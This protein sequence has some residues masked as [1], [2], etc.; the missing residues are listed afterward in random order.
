MVIMSNISSQRCYGITT[1][2]DYHPVVRFVMGCVELPIRAALYA[3]GGSLLL[4][5]GIL[6]ISFLAIASIGAIWFESGREWLGQQLKTGVK[7]LLYSGQMFTKSIAT[8]LLALSFLTVIPHVIEEFTKNPESK[9]SLDKV[10]TFFGGWWNSYS[11]VLLGSDYYYFL[12]VATIAKKMIPFCSS[13][14]SEE[15]KKRFRKNFGLSL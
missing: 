2:A 14:L 7:Q 4:L 12:D 6:R 8:S 3:L 5:L 1:Y 15:E 11:Q 13:P 10:L 9:G